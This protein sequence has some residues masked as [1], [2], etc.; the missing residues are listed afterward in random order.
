MR[1]TGYTDEIGLLWREIESS[2]RMGTVYTWTVCVA[3]MFGQH[4]YEQVV[5]VFLY[6]APEIIS[7]NE[8]EL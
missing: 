8:M 1:S 2:S 5:Q 4:E 3:C 7:E 6:R